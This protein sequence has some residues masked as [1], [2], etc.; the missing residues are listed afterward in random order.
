MN[1]KSENDAASSDE[2]EV[3]GSGEKVH[4]FRV[5]LDVSERITATAKKE[6][7]RTPAAY[8]RARMI[9]EFGQS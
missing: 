4:H 8:L 3:D 5:P 2:V 1:K 9:R 6:G 7:F